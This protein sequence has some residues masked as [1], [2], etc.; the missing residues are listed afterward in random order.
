MT[1]AME[2]DNDYKPPPKLYSGHE[3]YYVYTRPR[4][5]IILSTLMV[6]FGSSSVNPAQI[7]R[8]IISVTNNAKGPVT[9]V[10]HQI[11][12]KNMYAI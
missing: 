6:D 10:W 5:D 1:E 2:V 9:F 11:F 8:Q 12:A 7:A 4:E 3:D